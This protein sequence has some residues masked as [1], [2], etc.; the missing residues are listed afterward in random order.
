[1]WKHPSHHTAK[2]IKEMPSVKNNTVTLF[3]EHRGTLLMN[4][5]DHG[6][7]LTSEYCCDTLK[8]SEQATCCKMC[9]LSCQ[10]VICPTNQPDLWLFMVLQQGSY[11]QPPHSPDLMHSDSISLDYSRSTWLACDMQHMLTSRKLWLSDWRHLT[12][13]SRPGY[14]HWCSDVTMLKMST[15]TTCV[16]CV[17]SATNMPCIHRHNKVLGISPCY[18]IV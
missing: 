6:N 1:M 4:F 18:P 3:W 13:T 5:L 2:A 17:P 7:T 12:L 15:V 8:M 9:G 10:G 16:L 11:G 14:V